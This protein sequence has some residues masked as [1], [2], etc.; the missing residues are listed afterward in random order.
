MKALVT[1]AT[2]FVG[3]AVA[4]ALVRAG[5]D[6]RVLARAGADLQNLEGLTVERVE[7]DLRD[8]ASLGR[9]LTG[10]Q[11]LYHVAAHY[12]LWAKDPSIFYDVN[13]TGT[14]NLLEAARNSRHGTD[15][16]L[17]HHRRDR[18]SARRRTRH[19]RDTRLA[20]SDGRP[21]QTVEVPG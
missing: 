17:Q 1:G 2:G 3:G 16:L 4:R 15:R 5:I 6:V 20:R 13:V 14:K 7:G 8:Q 10:C 19:G 21:L 18:P 12:A 11:Q 9:A